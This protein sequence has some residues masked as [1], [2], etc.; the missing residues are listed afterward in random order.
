MDRAKLASGISS[1]MMIKNDD[2]RVNG[3]KRFAFIAAPICRPTY[4]RY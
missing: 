4:V 2:D 3:Y 1:K